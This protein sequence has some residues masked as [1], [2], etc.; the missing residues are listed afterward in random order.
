[1]TGFLQNRFFLSIVKKDNEVFHQLIFYLK[2]SVTITPAYTRYSFI[3]IAKIPP[4]NQGNPCK[5][6]R[7][8]SGFIMRNCWYFPDPWFLL[9]CMFF[10]FSSVNIPKIS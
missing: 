7:M 3:R 1:V 2:Y 5:T 4:D 8:N 6:I 10:D 9:R